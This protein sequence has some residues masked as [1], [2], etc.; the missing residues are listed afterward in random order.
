MRTPVEALVE[1]SHRAYDRGMKEDHVIP[2]IVIPAPEATTVVG[3]RPGSEGT[4]V[5]GE[6]SLSFSCGQCGRLLLEGVEPGDAQGM[7]FVCGCGAY[8]TTIEFFD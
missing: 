2:L 5:R 8:N 6:G 3:G 1:I 7:T 4:P